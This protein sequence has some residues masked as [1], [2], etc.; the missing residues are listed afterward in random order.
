[1]GDSIADMGMEEGT[2]ILIGSIEELQRNRK[3][4]Q[5]GFQKQEKLL[6]EIGNM[7]EETMI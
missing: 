5:A 2:E 3:S 1:L 6:F 7:V 4:V